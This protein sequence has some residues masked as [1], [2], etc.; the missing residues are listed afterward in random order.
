MSAKDKSF[1]KTITEEL[2]SEM[3]NIKPNLLPVSELEEVKYD[4][5]KAAKK[6]SE[7]AFLTEFLNKDITYTLKDADFV[8]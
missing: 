4:A 2:D 5:E 8:Q 7:V 3:E 6:V 1:A